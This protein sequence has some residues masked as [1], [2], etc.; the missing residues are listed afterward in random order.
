[1][2]FNSTTAILSDRISLVVDK[3]TLNPIDWRF[4]AAAKGMTSSGGGPT[5]LTH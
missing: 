5:R 2:T 4:S 1:V 3:M